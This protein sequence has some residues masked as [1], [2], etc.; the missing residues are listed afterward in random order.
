MGENFL[1]REKGEF[2]ALDKSYS[3]NISL[4]AQTNVFDLEIGKRI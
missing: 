2:F 4:F 1:L 3:W